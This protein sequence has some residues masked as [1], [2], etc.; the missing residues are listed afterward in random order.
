M[1]NKDKII[2]LH[3]LSV[4][5]GMSEAVLRIHLAVGRFSKYIV[6]YKKP[7]SFFYRYDFLS[8]L[9]AFYTDKLSSNKKRCRN[10]A[11]KAI[12]RINHILK[13]L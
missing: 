10:S 5:L 4:L 7:L 2:T 9:M 11:C 3:L 6:P 12:K 13:F 8:E 1:N